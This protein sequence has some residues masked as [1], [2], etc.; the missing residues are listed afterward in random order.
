MVTALPVP[1]D[2]AKAADGG[3]HTCAPA[4]IAFAGTQSVNNAQLG[5]NILNGVQVAINEHNAANPKCQVTLKRF[6]TEGDPAKAPGIVTQVVNESD[7][8][9]VIGLPFSGESKA[10][11]PIFQQAGLVHVTPSATNVNLTKNGWTTFFRGL[12]N[13]GVQGQAVGTFLTK[14]LQASKV[15][16]IQD[17]SDYGTGLATVVKS[18]LGSAD[19]TA[20]DDKVTT[21]QRDFSATVN[22]VMAAGADAVFYSG[23]YQE[24]APLDQQ[25]VNKG[26]TGKF[27]G[28]DGSKDEQ[29][30]K[31]AGA[32]ASNAYFTCPCVPGD[33]VPNFASAYQKVSGGSAPST[34]S[35]EGYDAT[36][37]LLRGIDAGNGTRASLLNYV[38]NYNA[39]GLSKHFQWDSTGEL[40]TKTVY[41]YKVDNGSIAYVGTIS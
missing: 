36:T 29:F 13:D 38:K 25:L 15:C 20:C 18:A 3:N 4:T 32:A 40:T 14:Q 9:G 1:A 16:V 34:Y 39:D 11:G 22:K 21:G 24:A 41:G 6:D 35:L 23:Y 5:I 27:V 10:T 2:A 31:L 33:L 19:D 37:I 7:I 26:F 17:D 30:I 12:A 8:I 28:P